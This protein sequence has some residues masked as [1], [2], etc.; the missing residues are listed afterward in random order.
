MKQKLL[1]DL[2]AWRRNQAGESSDTARFDG[3]LRGE[4]NQNG[5]KTVR[6][7]ALF[8]FSCRRCENAPCINACPAQALEKD[9]DGMIR[10][11]T[12]RCVACKSCVVIC[13]FGTIMNDFFEH[14]RQKE[15][16]F[17]L[18]DPAELETFL[19][20]HPEI[21]VRWISGTECEDPGLFALTDNIL[22]R[23]TSWEQYKNNAL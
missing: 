1:I 4:P 7:L 17:D 16:Y 23:E 5:L 2:G 3:L 10:R 22:I 14:H 11:S 13:P 21:R 19:R 18:D 8:R 12:H 20:L 15:R 9:E 6:E